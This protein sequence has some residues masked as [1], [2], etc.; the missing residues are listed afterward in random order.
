MP[1]GGKWECG[2]AVPLGQGAGSGGPRAQVV[3]S[4]VASGGTERAAS[5]EDS[6]TSPADPTCKV[7]FVG[8]H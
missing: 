2:S 7:A 8:T 1:E 6:S 5:P 4:E 3:V